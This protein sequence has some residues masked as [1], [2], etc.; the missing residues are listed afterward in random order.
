MFYNVKDVS[1]I[2]NCSDSKAYKTIHSLREQLIAGGWEPPPA[3]K[4]QKS[5]FCERFRLDEKETEKLLKSYSSKKAAN[6]VTNSNR[7]RGASCKKANM[8]GTTTLGTP[9]QDAL[10]TA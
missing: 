7:K 3:G 9:I 1:V 6:A 10:T 5:Y 2:L 4:I 8:S